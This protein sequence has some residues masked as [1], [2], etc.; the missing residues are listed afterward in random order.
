MG[1]VPLEYASPKVKAV[2]DV[3]FRPAVTLLIL[4]D[5]VTA[6][7]AGD[8]GIIYIDRLGAVTAWYIS[9]ALLA[10]IAILGFLTRP[11]PHF[12]RAAILIL[13]STAATVAG[14]IQADAAYRELVTMLTR[15]ASSS[16]VVVYI[17]TARGA[18]L[19]TLE[20]AWYVGGAFATT[21]FLLL[22]YATFRRLRLR[23]SGGAAAST[24]A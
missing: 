5:L 8:V 1:E 4:I 24:K 22:L 9:A 14:F 18:L 19:A 7:A 20:I 3:R 10:A 15:N 6:V 17:E 11:Q 2:S 12:G 13:A 21:S 23:R 16:V